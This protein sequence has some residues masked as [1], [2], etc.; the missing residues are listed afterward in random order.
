MIMK[1][2]VITPLNNS[3]DKVNMCLMDD[4]RKGEKNLF[5][6]PLEFL[7]ELVKCNIHRKL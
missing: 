7:S 3:V 2:I 6:V 5:V 4:M 1:Q